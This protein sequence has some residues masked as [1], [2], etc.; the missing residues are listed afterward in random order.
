MYNRLV[1]VTDDYG[2]TQASDHIDQVC[3]CL[4]QGL[5]RPIYIY[6]P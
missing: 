3:V 4:A 6:S 2:D 1:D 5:V